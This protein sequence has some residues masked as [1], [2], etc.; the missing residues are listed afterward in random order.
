VAGHDRIAEKNTKILN[1]LDKIIGACESCD[2]GEV[3]LGGKV[4]QL[5]DAS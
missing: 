2:D 4:A 1:N 3:V 5:D